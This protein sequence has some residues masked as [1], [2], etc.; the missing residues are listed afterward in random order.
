MRSF[1]GPGDLDPCPYPQKDKCPLFCL[2][3]LL[4]IIIQFES[5]EFRKVPVIFVP[6]LIW[7]VLF[8]AISSS[9][10]DPCLRKFLIARLHYLIIRWLDLHVLQSK[11]N[12]NK[13]ELIC[14]AYC[15]SCSLFRMFLHRTLF[16]PYLYF[17]FQGKFYKQW[18]F[19][20][21]W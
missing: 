1:G 20:W 6:L 7:K 17:Y 21:K 12:C 8:Q 9:G 11:V 10:L 4:K 18:I 5:N 19:A 14:S 15:S 16:V 3:D 2:Q 13:T